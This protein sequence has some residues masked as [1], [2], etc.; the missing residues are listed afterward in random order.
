MIRRIRKDRTPSP[1]RFSYPIHNF[2][3]LDAKSEQAS[4]PL[5]MASYAYNISFKDEKLTLGPGLERGKYIDSSGNEHTFPNLLGP[6]I[7]MRKIFLYRKY[8]YELNKRQ[9]MLLVQTTTGRLFVCDF[10]GSDF[11]EVTAEA[12]IPSGANLHCIGYHLDGEDVLLI[13]LSTGG[14]RVYNGESFISYPL[15]PAAASACTHYERAWLCEYK[16]SNRLWFSPALNPVDFTPETDKGGY[17]TFPDEGGELQAVIS[18]KDY[19]YIFRE[20]CIHRLTA[21]GDPYD[22][23]LTKVFVSNNKIYPSTICPVGDK[24]M[25]YAE[26]GFYAFDG[27]AAS[28]VYE[29]VTPIIESMEHA[30]VCYFDGKYMLATRMKNVDNTQVGDEALAPYKNNALISFNLTT[31]ALAIMR[32]SDISHFLPINIENICGV[33]VSMSNFRA[34]EIYKV[35]DDGLLDNEPLKKLW[36]SPLANLSSIDR[37]K[38]LR[39]IFITCY[40]KAELG[41]TYDGGHSSYS[42]DALAKPQ[43]V[44]INKKCDNVRISLTSTEADFF[45]SSLQL[46]FDLMRYYYANK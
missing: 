40:G 29:R 37:Y 23:K 15:V 6:V 1:S 18:F 27:F 30:A 34:Y 38:V 36:S 25:F 32:G 35:T 31:G 8:N 14:M 28:K 13:Y 7:R 3:G 46:T 45:V 42:L 4:M 26:D 10:A 22:Y 19:L 20:F 11:N 41:V 12:D 5:S 43:R 24:I 17:I 16:G 44:P 33:Y 39:N 2:L 9:D 21:Y